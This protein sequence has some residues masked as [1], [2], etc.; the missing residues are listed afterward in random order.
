MGYVNSK[1]GREI[2][3]L[4]GWKD[5]IWSRRYQAILI[6]NEEE[7]QVARLKYVLA[8]GAKENLVAGPQ[9]WPG[10][11][12]VHPLLAGEWTVQGTWYDRR[13][14]YVLRRSGKDF[15]LDDYTSR[16]P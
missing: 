6:S 4:T 11:H 15:T 9:E 3:R 16:E 7:A 5:K 13:R 10:V 2:G 8:H 12:C 1:L 14:E